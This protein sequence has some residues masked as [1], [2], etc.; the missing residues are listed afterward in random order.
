MDFTAIFTFRITGRRRTRVSCAR[1]AAILSVLLTLLFPAAS[2]ADGLSA[3]KSCESD[4]NPPEETARLT[5]LP[6]GE[7]RGSD[8]AAALIRMARQKAKEGKDDEAIRWAV[9][10]Q[11][12]AKEQD[13]IRRDSAAVLQYLKN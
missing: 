12:E 10:C 7:S 4:E 1:E 13:E 6:N 9:L 11:F 3:V 5:I 8:T 2:K